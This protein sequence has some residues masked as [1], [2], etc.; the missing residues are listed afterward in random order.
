MRKGLYDP[1]RVAE[2]V[3]RVVCRGEK[4][5]Y[6]RFRASRFY[7]G[8]AVADTVGC[9]LNCVFCWVDIP[10]THIRRVGSF[11]SPADVLRRLTSI[12]SS[13][14]FG[15]IRLSGGEPTL[16]RDHLL[17]LLS[18]PRKQVFILETNGTLLDED[19][20]SA[21]SGVRGLHVRV[22]VKGSSPA[23]FSRLTGAIPEAY[24]WVFRGIDLLREYGVPH[25]V[26]LVHWFS[27]SRDLVEV[28]ARLDSMGERV[29]LESFIP[30][31][32]VV[33]RLRKAGIKLKRRF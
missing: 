33:E 1:R 17:S 4:R 12:A 11:Y 6:Y 5:K 10:R 2:G 18:L 20:V 15:Y 22:S 21:L 30:Y 14:G 27:E 19:L 32:K 26:S 28:L 16:C 8:S 7:G 3:K 24:E 23:E 13:R 29:E 25:H 31:P 9:N